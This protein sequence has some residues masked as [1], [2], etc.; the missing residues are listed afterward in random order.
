MVAL[1]H[2][3]A[4]GGPRS[5]ASTKRV[6]GRRHPELD[7]GAAVSQRLVEAAHRG[8]A[9]A[10]AECLAD[11]AADVNHA[12]AVCLRTRQVAMAL[13]EEAA[14]EIRVEHVDLRTDASAL[15][16]AAHAGD[17]PLVR[18]L[19]VRSPPSTLLHSVFI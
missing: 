6:A 17:L 13:R 7:H 14:D 4:G 15:F 11:P 9:R 10:A 1:V 3:L 8:D 19:L 18:R 12:G 16:V 2:S 5:L